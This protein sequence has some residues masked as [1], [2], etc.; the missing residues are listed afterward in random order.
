MRKPLSILI[1]PEELE[2]N[3]YLKGSG[4]REKL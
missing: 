1:T 2:Y 3:E 4:K